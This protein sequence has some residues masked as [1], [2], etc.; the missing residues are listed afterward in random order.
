M[1]GACAGDEV[2]GSISDGCQRFGTAAGL[3]QKG[4]TVGESPCMGYPHGSFFPTTCL[5]CL[6]SSPDLSLPCCFS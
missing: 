2:G 5:R 3:S 6:A 4:K 1:G